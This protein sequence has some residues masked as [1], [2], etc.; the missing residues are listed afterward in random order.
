MVRPSPRLAC[1]LL[2][3]VVAGCEAKGTSGTA[4]YRDVPTGT[5]YSDRDQPTPRTT[6]ELRRSEASEKI[7][8]AVDATVDAARA[9]RDEYAVEARRQLNELDAKLADLNARAARATGDAKAELDKKAAEAKVKR[10]AAA[11]RLEEL[12][13]AG[14]ERWEKI[15][16]GVGN[17]LDDL[18][19]AFE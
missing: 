1:G 13:T 11:E 15:K 18:R 12:Q 3:A 9:K 16:V 2:I 14:S 5:A 6:A 19:R 17:A 8:D 7:G 10:E 4:G